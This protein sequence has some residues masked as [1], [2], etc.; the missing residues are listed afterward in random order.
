MGRKEAIAARIKLARLQAG[1]S[2][3]E[4]GQLYGSSDVN[5]SEIER[6]ITNI[7]VP[8]LERLSSILGKPLEWFL[9]DGVEVPNRPL[10][11][12]LAEAQNRYGELGILELPV[13]GAVPGNCNVILEERVEGYLPIS[14]R[15]LRAADVTHKYKDMYLL[16]VEDDSLSGDRIYSGDVLVV[17]PHYK[18]TDNKIYVVKVGTRVMARRLCE[19]SGVMQVIECKEGD[20][21]VEVSRTDILGR[22]IISGQ[23]IVH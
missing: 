14:K 12:I 23:W 1:L 18:F 10:E 15:A 16:R 20:E 17:D 2:Q 6:G 13:W 22:V 11:V 19:K 4:L 3:R 9:S 8:S 21:P 7:D 5:I